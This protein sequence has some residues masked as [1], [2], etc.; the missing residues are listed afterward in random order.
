MNEHEIQNLIRLRLGQF[1]E[2]RIFRANVGQGWSGEA[3]IK[4]P[5]GDVRITRPRPLNTGLPE[6]WPDL[7]GFRLL[8]VT[9]DMAGL[10][11]PV[12]AAIEVKG[13]RGALRDSQRRV[14]EELSRCGCFSGIARS[15]EEALEILRLEP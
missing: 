4:L 2:V 7:F 9:H 1:P 8:T 11:L 6:G 15:P 13:P 14:L 3:V 12:F 10:T 5:G